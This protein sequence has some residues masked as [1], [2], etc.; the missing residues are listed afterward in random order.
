MIFLAPSSILL[1]SLSID[2]L[3]KF[4]P[5]WQI[6]CY[7]EENAYFRIYFFFFK[8]NKSEKVGG[9]GHDSRQ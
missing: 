8:K 4:C 1:Q 5:S 3:L 6:H 2:C 9:G 7:T